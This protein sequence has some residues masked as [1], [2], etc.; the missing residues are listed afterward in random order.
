[1]GQF[2]SLIHI[3][4]YDLTIRDLQA[5]WAAAAAEAMALCGTLGALY[6]LEMTDAAPA[7][8]WGDGVLYDRA[9]V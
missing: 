3:L 1:M 8:D 4:D 7:I 6:G 2:L 9:R 5:A